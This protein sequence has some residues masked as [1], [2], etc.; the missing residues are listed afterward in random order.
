MNN[1]KYHTEEYKAK[2]KEKV[3]RKFGPVLEHTKVCEKCGS[4]Y[5]FVGREKSKSFHSSRFCSRKCAN[6][7]GG[8]AKAD[9]HHTDETCHYTTV[10][11]RHHDKK[12]V[13]CG[14]ENVVAVHHLNENHKDNDPKNLVPLCPTHHQYMHSKHKHLIEDKV[15][16]Y[17]KNKWG[18]GLLG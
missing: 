15:S 10:A 17:V 13:I 3:D 4:E 8:R 6:S 16:E 7:V 12:C 18:V 14:E 5:I 2:Q 1:G 11:W 9:K